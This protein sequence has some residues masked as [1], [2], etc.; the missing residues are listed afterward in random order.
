MCVFC[1]VGSNVSFIIKNKHVKQRLC[2]GSAF[3]FF[4]LKTE[5]PAGGRALRLLKMASPCPGPL[6]R[7]LQSTPPRFLHT[8]ALPFCETPRQ[9]MKYFTI[10]NAVEIIELFI[11]LSYLDWVLRKLRVEPIRINSLNTQVPTK[12]CIRILCDEV[13]K[14]LNV[15][16]KQS[17]KVWRAILDILVLSRY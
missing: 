13:S 8:T 16:S 1:T 10:Y 9:Q 6:W 15:F 12:N 17:W 7:F 2:L 3:S 14:I 11:C 4:F 5:L